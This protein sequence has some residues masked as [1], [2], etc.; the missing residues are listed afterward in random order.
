[1]LK[2][3][4]RGGRLGA[5]LTAAVLV[6]TAG[7]EGMFDVTNP[8]RILDED[9]NSPDMVPTL[10]VGMS[11]DFSDV[12]DGMA[13]NV[14]RLT[15]EISGSG[16]YFNTGRFRKGI[17]DPDDTNGLWEQT[18]EARFMADDGLRR[19]QEDV[20][21]FNFNNNP[22]V[23]RAYL[24]Q[25]LANRILGELF[26]EVA[27]DGGAPEPRTVA[28]ERAINALQQAIS[29]GDGSGDEDGQAYA[30]AARGGIAQAYVGL[31]DW[32]QAVQYASQVPTDFEYVAYY[33]PGENTNVI[34]NETHGR[35]EISTYGVLAGQFDEPGE[36]RAPYIKCGVMQGGSVEGTGKAGC[37][38]AQGADG[39]TPHWMQMKYDTNGG[40]I[41]VV[42]GEEMRLIEAEAALR[43]NDL[44]T[45][46]MKINEVR[47]QY[48]L[49]PIDEP[50]EVGELNY[51][52]DLDDND[53]WS[54]LDRERHLTLWMEG[55]RLWDLH[56]WD[57]PFLAGGVTI[58]EAAINPRASCLPIAQSECEVNDNIPCT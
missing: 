29:H 40:D 53:A 38:Y 32:D 51:P 10:V 16:S 49:D 39:E 55:R 26:C 36:P 43:N 13:F 2:H 23:A 15:D 19:M 42:S 44:G 48:G 7:C 5:L 18:H 21:G 34:Y 56:R 20:E 1:M 37:T 6:V 35:P 54:I 11:A 27:Y 12:V 31:G 50:A 24:F 47:A 45:F 28:F 52:H 33:H 9:L 57:H 30:T 4:T 25:G 17:L 8:G 46:T 3:R 22:L 58:D 41:R 14:A